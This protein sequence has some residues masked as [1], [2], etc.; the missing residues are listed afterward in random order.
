MKPRPESFDKPSTLIATELSTVLRW[1]KN[2]ILLMRRNHLDA[3]VLQIII[4]AVAVISFV[5]DQLLRLRFDHVEI[6]GQLNERDLMVIGSMCG[7]SQRKAVA[8]YNTHDFHAF[9]A[10]CRADAISSSLGWRE[11]CI[12]K[13]LAFIDHA[14]LAQG[15]CQLA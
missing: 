5:A 8:I 14:G 6:E 2:S 4:E 10:F 11:R 1:L 15:V 7:D 9:S 13:G 12:D 3:V